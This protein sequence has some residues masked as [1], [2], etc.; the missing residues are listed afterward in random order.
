M[1]NKDA[2]NA[3]L[4]LVQIDMKLDDRNESL[5]P[6]QTL[7][8]A[9]FIY[10]PKCDEFAKGR[11]HHVFGVSCLVFS[12]TLH[13]LYQDVIP[14]NTLVKKSFFDFLRDCQMYIGKIVIF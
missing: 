8:I 10:W 13:M 7:K 5:L 6:T 2:Y 3:K 11:I 12:L 9:G 4:K 1:F 14:L